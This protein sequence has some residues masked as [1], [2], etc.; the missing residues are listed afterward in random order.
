MDT[1]P[2][3]IRVEHGLTRVTYRGRARPAVSSVLLRDATEHARAHG[4]HW[5]LVDIR[6]AEDPDYH[7]NAIARADE[8]QARGFPADMRVALLG[9]P[10]DER[11]AYIDNVLHN[12]G[13]PVRVFDD[14][15]HALAWLM[16]A[17]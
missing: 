7:V 15:A 13:L 14:E 6:E 10:G 8:A 9:R 11:L 3:D 1:P 12:R 16:G 2:I 17:L 5:I 4:S